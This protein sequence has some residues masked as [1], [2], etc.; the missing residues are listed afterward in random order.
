MYGYFFPACMSVPHVYV[1]PIEARRLG[2][3]LELELQLVADCHRVLKIGR[4]S[5][6]STSHLS[7]HFIYFSV[8]HHCNKSFYFPQYP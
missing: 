2:D 1:V 3:P 4:R 6:A 5:S 8:L 7:R